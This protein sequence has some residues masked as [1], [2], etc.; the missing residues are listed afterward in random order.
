MYR[1]KE[2]VILQG[3]CVFQGGINMK[4]LLN[5]A[6]EVLV[7]TKKQFKNVISTIMR[8]DQIVIPA[9]EVSKK[10]TK[11][12]ASFELTRTPCSRV[13]SAGY[14]VIMNKIRDGHRILAN[15]EMNWRFM[16]FSIKPNAKEY[17]EKLFSSTIAVLVQSNGWTKMYI[18]KPGGKYVDMETG[19]VTSKVVG[20]IHIYKG[21]AWTASNKRQL[22][23][24]F[25]EVT[26][27]DDRFKILDD[28]TLGALRKI[29]KKY[30]T[31]AAVKEYMTK[32]QK[33]GGY[34]GNV[35]TGSISFG[36]VPGWTRYYGSWDNKTPEYFLNSEYSK[37]MKNLKEAS[38]AGDKV[39]VSDI[40]KELEKL[41]KKM[42]RAATQDGQLYIN[43]RVLADMIYK[44]YGIIVSEKVLMGLIIQ[45]R[46]ATIK[47]SGLVV[48]ERVFNRIVKKTYLMAAKE[49]KA[50]LA[51]YKAMLARGE[52]AAKAEAWKNDALSQVEVKELGDTENQLFVADSN[53]VK[54]DFDM[55]RD[56]T[57]EIL[58]FCKC[59]K[60]KSSKQM[61]ESLLASN[62]PRAMQ[63][64]Y[65]IVANDVD[66]S[67][68][69]IMNAKARLL[70]PEEITEA[71]EKGYS[72]D[73][74]TAMYPELLKVS[75]AFYNSAWKQ[76]LNS[77][78]GKI[79]GMNGKLV[80]HNRRLASDLTF[81]LS[82]GKISS[83]LKVGEVFINNRKISK[84][85]MIKYPKM[86]VREFYCAKNVSL[87]EI[88]RR[89]KE[90]TKAGII[91]KEESMD[92]YEL[93]Q[94]IDSDIAV[95]PGRMTTAAACAGL[96][97][98]YDGSLFLEYTTNPAEDDTTA[99]LTNELI[100]ILEAFE[101]EAVI[102]DNGEDEE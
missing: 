10:F 58:A 54:L 87:R 70:T 44:A 35:L 13:Y 16:A 26:N 88:K 47:A 43:A 102:I 34:I 95:L 50:I 68:A 78:F 61:L 32:I 11:L 17:A 57:F 30:G 77:I 19:E 66:D 71:V 29:Y 5:K 20:E 97:Y 46:P 93:Y 28:A 92:I 48:S 74:L 31:D 22:S 79:D 55:T 24:I 40:K 12:R 90:Y 41:K 76:K 33:A 67:M 96:D 53:C 59:S 84:V 62:D 27:G 25:M 6:V 60:G 81:I 94:N 39:A 89:L 42:H 2:F 65:D 56:I 52:D 69:E 4:N 91:T 23:M 85:V 1:T 14:N 49:S 8:K 83:L 98:D 45:L 21:L 100:D 18:V 80:S 99:I 3:A 73:V 51:E 86:G 38:K 37:A 36:V 75:K 63:L 64:C 101:M 9:I 7:K 72:T 82:N 15:K